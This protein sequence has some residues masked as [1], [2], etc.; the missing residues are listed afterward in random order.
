MSGSIGSTISSAA[1]G[2]VVAI[3]TLAYWWIRARAAKVRTD[4]LREAVE[5]V[6][7]RTAAAVGP[8]TAADAPA[9]AEPEEQS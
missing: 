8:P 6:P 4:A 7:E 5:K 2:V 3:L 9:P 1:S